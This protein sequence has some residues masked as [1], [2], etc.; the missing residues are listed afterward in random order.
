MQ[1][2]D[3]FKLPKNKTVKLL[4]NIGQYVTA[5][6]AICFLGPFFLAAVCALG[7]LVLA[8]P[9]WIVSLFSAHLADS[10]SY[11]VSPDWPFHLGLV[12]PTVVGCVTIIYGSRI[13]RAWKRKRDIEEEIKIVSDIQIAEPTPPS[14]VERFFGSDGPL[15]RVYNRCFGWIENIEN[16]RLRSVVGFVVFVGVALPVGR[17][18]MW[19]QGVKL[20][21]QW[22]MIL[23]AIFFGYV[24]ILV[25]IAA[26]WTLYHAAWGVRF[27]PTWLAHNLPHGVISRYRS[28]QLRRMARNRWPCD[29]LGWLLTLVAIALMTLAA[30]GAWQLLTHGRGKEDDTEEVTDD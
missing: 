1:K 25:A 27:I 23:V 29:P 21:S 10:L 3:A 28:W 26:G 11:V 16:D 7:V 8:L 15:E 30:V 14:R 24:W 22:E 6:I 13:S 18:A 2:S 5:A 12:I 20:E 19:L 9:V 17:T 4:G